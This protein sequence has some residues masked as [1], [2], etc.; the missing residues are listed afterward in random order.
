M[1]YLEELRDLARGVRQSL[2]SHEDVDA[3][4]VLS[5]LNRLIQL[6]IAE[7]EWQREV[8]FTRI[9]PSLFPVVGEDACQRR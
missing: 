5:D 3:L 9:F 2:T 4:G 6:L 8:G 7:K 1:D